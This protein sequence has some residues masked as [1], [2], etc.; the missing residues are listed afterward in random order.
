MEQLS[1]PQLKSIIPSSLRSGITQE[2]L[3]SINK[4][5]TDEGMATAFKE[6]LISFTSVSFWLGWVFVAGR[7]VSRCHNQEIFSSF[8]E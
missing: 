8:S 4:I 5:L 6:N 2:M 1:L 3:D 7:G